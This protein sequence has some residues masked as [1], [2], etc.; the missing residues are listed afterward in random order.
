MVWKWG[1]VSSVF[2]S[3]LLNSS[4]MSFRIFTNGNR[5]TVWAKEFTCL[6]E[7]RV[8][9][10]SVPSVRACSLLFSCWSQTRSPWG[11]WYVHGEGWGEGGSEK[12]RKQIAG[13]LIGSWNSKLPS[14]Y[15]VPG[16]APVFLNH[17]CSLGKVA[18]LE[19]ILSMRKLRF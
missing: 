6:K 11:Q 19:S 14:I 18:F 7:W 9:S 10:H 5:L 1:G 13:P 12:K 3:N 16:P 17:L 8:S 15:C 2:S 4:P